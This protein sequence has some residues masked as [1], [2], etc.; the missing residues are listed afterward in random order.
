MSPKRLEL[1]RHLHM[2]GPMSVRALSK[3][4]NR[5]YNSVHAD[6]ASLTDTGLIERL[7]DDLI[8][9]PWDKVVSELNFT[10]LTSDISASPQTL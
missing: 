9:A 6:S 8:H 5:D 10:K 7:S 2:F 1:M 4:L 3:A